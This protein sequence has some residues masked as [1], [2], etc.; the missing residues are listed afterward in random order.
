M[1]YDIYVK[2]AREDVHTL[3]YIVEAEDNLVNIR[4]YENGLL[5]ILT[6]E[7]LKDE[8]LDFLNELKNFIPLEVV[9]VRVNNGDI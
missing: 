8:V 2:M 1:E 9:D 3:G 6:T 5:R 4:K 7:G